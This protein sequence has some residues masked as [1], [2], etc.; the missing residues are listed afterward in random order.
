MYTKPASA[1]TDPYSFLGPIN[2]HSGYTYQIHTGENPTQTNVLVNNGQQKN[3]GGQ[4]VGAYY[5]KLTALPQNLWLMCDKVYDVI[6]I[7]HANN[8]GSNGMFGD[9]HVEFA[10]NSKVKTLA[11]FPNPYGGKA[12]TVFYLWETA[13][14]QSK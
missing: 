3:V 14:S 12:Y 11:S 13:A 5:T 4:Y 1:T 7:P 8:A 2:D 10:Q 9:A 6:S